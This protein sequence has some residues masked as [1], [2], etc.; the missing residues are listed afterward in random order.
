[1]CSIVAHDKK[2]PSYEYEEIS[3]WD[4]PIPKNTTT[5][6]LESVV[7]TL[8]FIDMW[9]KLFDQNHDFKCEMYNRAMKK[10]FQKYQQ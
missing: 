1:M 3:N 4:R 10:M 5:E 8:N 2:Q 7:S 6:S 9:I